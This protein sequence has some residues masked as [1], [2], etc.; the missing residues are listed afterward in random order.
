MLTFKKAFIL[1]V[2]AVAILASSNFQKA[3]T[4]VSVLSSMIGEK[5]FSCQRN[6]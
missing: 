2:V 4:K 6:G 5:S 3:N 1:G